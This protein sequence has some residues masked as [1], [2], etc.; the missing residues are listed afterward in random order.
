MIFPGNIKRM[1]TE[2]REGTG[3]SW[4]RYESQPLRADKTSSLISN[5]LLR[6]LLLR[7]L[8]LTVSAKDTVCSFSSLAATIAS[9]SISDTWSMIQF[10]IKLNTLITKETTSL[11]S[12]LWHYPNRYNSNN[13]SLSRP[14]FGTIQ[15]S[16]DYNYMKGQKRAGE[17]MPQ[18]QTRCGVPYPLSPILLFSPFFPIPYP[19]PRRLRTLTRGTR[20]YPVVIRRTKRKNPGK[21]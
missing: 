3:V 6:T 21:N 2:P 11:Y 14:V 19:F 15:E 4:R 12:T 8:Q 16:L 9:R 17:T 13:H 5:T 10:E 18:P 7:I 20:V 1:I